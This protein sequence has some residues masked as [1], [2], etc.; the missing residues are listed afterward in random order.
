M[1]NTAVKVSASPHRLTILLTGDGTV[2]GPVLD[3]ASLLEM[4]VEGPLK[5]AWNKTYANQDAMRNAL[6]AGDCHAQ[7]Q[8]RESGVDIT[9]QKNQVLI[10]VDTDA[11]TASKAEIN[12]SMSDTS[13][14][15]AYLHLICSHSL[16]Q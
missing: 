16:V 14:Q 7:I 10:D 9:A 4:M 8:L 5:K 11:V 15:V 2:V 13:G 12:P 1:A 3:N 6:L